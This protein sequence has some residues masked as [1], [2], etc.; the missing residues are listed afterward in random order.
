M[1][2]PI[3]AWPMPFITARTSAKSRLIW[4][5]TVMMSLMP[6]TAWRSTSSATRKASD[7]GVLRATVWSSRSLGIAITESTHS[8][9]WARPSMAWAMRRLPSRP[10]GSVTTATVSTLP[11]SPPSWPAI[12]ATTGAAPVPVPPPRPVVM[13]TMSAPSSASQIFSV[14][15]TAA[16]R[17]TSGLAPAPRP[18]VSLPPIWILTGARL[19]RSACRSVLTAMNSTPCSPEAIMRRDGVAAAAAHAHHLDA[20][21][22]GLVVGEGDPARPVV[23]VRH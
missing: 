5:G 6:C 12:E 11:L 18:L 21:A 2:V 15:S 20:G 19:L 10:K 13:K 16:C 22:A 14:S 1:P 7:T 23:L 8:W 4:P 17:P 3:T 9:S